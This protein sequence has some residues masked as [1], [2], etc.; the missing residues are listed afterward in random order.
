MASINLKYTKAQC[1]RQGR[2]VYWYFRRHG[3][4]WRLPGQPL[5]DEF[6]EVC[7]RLLALTNASRDPTGCTLR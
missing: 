7:R 1:D 3:K 2:E 5:S 6:A 4:Q